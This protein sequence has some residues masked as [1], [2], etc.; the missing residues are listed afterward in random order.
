MD[1]AKNLAEPTLDRAEARV[2]LTEAR[3][4]LT[5]ARFCL[6]LHRFEF[7]LERVARVADGRLRAPLHFERAA[8]PLVVVVAAAAV[9]VVVF[10]VGRLRAVSWRTRF[11]GA[12][13][14]P[15]V[16]MA[17]EGAR[18]RAAPM[19]TSSAASS[20]RVRRKSLLARI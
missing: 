1:C 6:E 13:K 15:S 7:P 19:A 14:R 8:L 11:I 4:H 17:T 9:V 5:E 2:H 16:S 3:V 12:C 20:T 18:E 10:S